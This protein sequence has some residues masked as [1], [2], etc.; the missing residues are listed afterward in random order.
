M[1]KKNKLF[2]IYSRAFLPSLNIFLQVRSIHWEYEAVAWHYA[3][4][5]FP[6]QNMIT[7]A[8]HVKKH[9]IIFIHLDRFSFC[10]MH[11]RLLV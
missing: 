4:I 5:D 2:Y 1:N 7:G 9:K 10:V 3:H 6:E 11:R 8:G